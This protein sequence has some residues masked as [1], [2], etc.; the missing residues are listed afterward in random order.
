[1]GTYK[2]A[3]A[4][5]LFMVTVTYSNVTLLFT[6]YILRNYSLNLKSSKMESKCFRSVWPM[7]DYAV[8]TDIELSQSI[9][10]RWFFRLFILAAEMFSVY[11]H[12]LQ[13][14][15]GSVVFDPGQTQSAMSHVMLNGAL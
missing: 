15:R 8:T 14:A 3:I 7:N 1:M 2:Y 4:V 6:A 10:S 13:K 12:Y 5:R 9:C 11:D